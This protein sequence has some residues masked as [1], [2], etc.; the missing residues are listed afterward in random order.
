MYNNS[1][2]QT[3]DGFQWGPF[4]LGILYLILAFFAFNNPMV[5]I[6]SVAYLF[7]FG[8]TLIGLY[9]IFVRRKMRQHAGLSSGFVIAIGIIDILIGIFFLFNISAAVVALPFVFAVWLIVDSFGTIFSASPIREYSTAQYWFTV[10]AGILGVII[11][12]LLIFNPLSSFVA[13]TTLLGV[14]FMLF[15]I[16]HIVYAF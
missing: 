7:A 16:L 9:E 3:N 6:V 5:S 4:L 10:I 13:I 12:F 8:A 14:Y 11:G 2:R 1:N 15:G